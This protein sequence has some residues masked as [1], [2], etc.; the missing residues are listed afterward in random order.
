MEGKQTMNPIASAKRRRRRPRQP[1]TCEDLAR[2]GRFDL[3]LCCP[4][5]HRDPN[6]WLIH[7]EITA[8]NPLHGQCEVLICCRA[9]LLLKD[10]YSDRQY[11]DLPE[12]EE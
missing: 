12:H 11:D 3:S 4:D 6:R 8:L 2:D 9:F 1:M 10:W 7:H 5:C